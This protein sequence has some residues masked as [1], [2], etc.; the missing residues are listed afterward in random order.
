LTLLS[1]SG[2]QFTTGRT[3]YAESHGSQEQSSKIWIAVRAVQL[4]DVPFTAQL[5]TGAAWS[6][7]AAELAEEL[8]LF[9]AERL[10]TVRISTR[11]GSIEGHLVRT[12]LVL[13][14]QAGA[15]L[16]VDATVWASRKWAGPNFIGYSG[17]LERLRFAVDP[18]AGRNHF[19]F[20]AAG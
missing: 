1:L 11:A 18:S 3:A 4:R 16:E 5:D 14:A 13:E 6:M 19:H 17:F 9:E 8:G 10:G 7:L 20:G 2:E 15:S 12:G